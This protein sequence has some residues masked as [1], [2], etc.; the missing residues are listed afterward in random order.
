MMSSCRRARQPQL[1]TRARVGQEERRP[2]DPSRE[3]YPSARCEK[4]VA[5]FGVR[6]ERALNVGLGVQT[7]RVRRDGDAAPGEVISVVG[8]PAI[9]KYREAPGEVLPGVV[10]GTTADPV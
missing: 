9:R 5:Q 7:E 10:V 1:E 4:R 2:C 8:S 3:M 6:G